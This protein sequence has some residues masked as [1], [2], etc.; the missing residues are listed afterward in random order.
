MATLTATAT[1]TDHRDVG[2]SDA[3]AVQITELIIRTREIDERMWALNRQGK[4]PFVVPCR[5]QEAAQAGAAWALDPARDWLFPHYRDLALAQRFGFTLDELF[6]MF[7]AKADDPISGG[8]Q[9][10]HHFGAQARH[11]ASISSPLGT[12]IPH[13]V[14]GA[15]ALR[16]Q[17]KT[18]AAVLVGFGEG[19]AS[20]GDFYEACSLAALHKLPVIFFCQNN[21]YAISVPMEK[22]SPVPN[23]ADRAAAFG[24]PGVI[25]DGSDPFAVYDAVRRAR[26]RGVAGGGP[27]LIEA[28]MYRLL[29]HTSDDNDMTYRTR[30]EV[31]QAEERECV[32]RVTEYMRERGLLTADAIAEMRARVRAEIAAAVAMAQAA[33]DPDPATLMDHV[34]APVEEGV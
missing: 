17:G 24:M 18:D 23:V 1:L 33:P 26:A 32:R 6:L 34:Y 10:T 31:R 25:V 22:Q 5:G 21:Q 8:R 16:L 14:G 15:Y 30:D 7:F 28:K 20:K 2:L 19:T 3:D 9:M 13:A 12:Q 27:T 29:P 4:V 11:V